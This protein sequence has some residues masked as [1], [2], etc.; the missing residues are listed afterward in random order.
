MEAEFDPRNPRDARAFAEGFRAA[1]TDAQARREQHRKYTDR[2]DEAKRN[3]GM[4]A[5]CAF[6]FLSTAVTANSWGTGLV[7][8]VIGVGIGVATFTEARAWRTNSA[9]AAQYEPT[10]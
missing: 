1:C 6:F 8:L 5:L 3:A 4:L 10:T 9:A 2:A 7:A